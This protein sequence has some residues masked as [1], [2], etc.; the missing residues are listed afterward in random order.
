[1]DGTTLCPHCDT[2]F[3][4]AYT[5]LDA[6]QGMVRCG[7]CREVFDARINFISDEPNP[8]LELVIP[9]VVAEP[10]VLEAETLDSEAIDSKADETEA[11]ETEQIEEASSLSD[12]ETAEAVVVDAERE[13]EIYNDSLDFSIPP[14]PAARFLE[15]AAY[16]ESSEAERELTLAEQVEVVTDDEPETEPHSSHTALWASL[17]ALLAVILISQAVYY[18]RTDIAARMPALKPALEGYCELLSCSVNLPKNNELMSIESSTLEAD[19][20]NVA[21]ITLT[22]LLRN[23][24]DY[25]L[26]YPDLEL[27]LNDRQDKAVARRIFKPKDYLPAKESERLGLQANNEL[28]IKLRLDTTD[29]D[30]NGY[31]LAVYYQSS[32]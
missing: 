30:P 6:H 16:M 28:S 32:H 12:E 31:R 4:V 5:Q 15:K 25:V 27:T 21:H 29:L 11:H 17:S 1:M 23:R 20:D 2:R 8:R 19:S 7:H 14:T 24:A 13:A 26:A 18:F 10:L 3:K 22:A 9:E